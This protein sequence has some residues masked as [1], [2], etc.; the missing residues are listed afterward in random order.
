MKRLP[1][2]AAAVL[3]LAACPSDDDGTP[4][5]DVTPDADRTPDAGENGEEI[6]G[7]TVAYDED[8][9]EVG[10]AN[11]DCLGEPDDLEPT[12]NE[13]ELSG[14]ITEFM[15]GDLD[16][17]EVAAFDDRDF[18]ADPIAGPVTAEENGEDGEIVFDE[19]TLPEGVGRVAIRMTAEDHLETHSLGQTFEPDATEEEL[20]ME[21]IALSTAD[22]LAQSTV[23]RPVTEGLGHVAGQALDC[24]GNALGHVVAEISTESG[25]LEPYED[26]ER[27][28]YFIGGQLP[29]QAATEADVDGQFIIPEVEPSE[30]TLYVQVWGYPD[31]EAYDEGERV[32]LSE[33]DTTVPPDGLV[34][35]PLLPLAEESENGGGENGG[36]SDD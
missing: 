36:D 5:A 27:T 10:D 22:L 8:G 20:E 32:L 4:D 24:D 14:E 28:F 12:E 31:Q 9:D 35:A 6:S 7:P 23:D 26:A 2:L 15:G 13:I 19:L 1:W 18:F 34:S 33:L 17:V 21:I 3:A 30:E 11:W 29:P 25:E 16:E